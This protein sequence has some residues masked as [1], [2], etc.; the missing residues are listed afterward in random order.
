MAWE[1]LCALWRRREVRGLDGQLV[2]VVDDA[3][4]MRSGDWA[5]TLA[6]AK[7]FLGPGHE[8]SAEFGGEGDTR[9]MRCGAAQPKKGNGQKSGEAVDMSMD[10]R[11][12]DRS[13]SEPGP[14]PW[15]AQ[16]PRRRA[17][18]TKAPVMVVL[19]VSPERTGRGGVSKCHV[20][21][22]L[23]ALEQEVNPRHGNVL[24][25][26][27]GGSLFFALPCLV[28]TAITVSKRRS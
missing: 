7:G 2:V 24:S 18:M 1:L 19:A 5:L 14:T 25:S 15:A 28:C 17:R 9:A 16:E 11:D 20:T 8:P 22:D 13:A 6:V 23:E 3:H 10:A 4:W 26:R 21:P 27:F 12:P